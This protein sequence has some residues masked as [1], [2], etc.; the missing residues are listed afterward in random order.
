MFYFIQGDTVTLRKQMRAFCLMCQRYI[1]SINT[2]V[3]E[4]VR[5]DESHFVFFYFLPL[6]HLSFFTAAENVCGQHFHICWSVVFIPGFHYTVW[7]ATDLQSP[8]YVF[9]PGTVGVSGLYTRFFF[10][11]RAAQLHPGSCFYWSGWWQQHRLEGIT[12]SYVSLTHF[13]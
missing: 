6:M 7:S 2:A 3:K 11:G 4:Q 10:A 1:N 5:F 12:Q 9:R 8:N 13:V